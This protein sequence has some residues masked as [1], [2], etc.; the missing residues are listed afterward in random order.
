MIKCGF[1]DKQ[2]ENTSV[3][4]PGLVKFAQKVEKQRPMNAVCVSVE[5]SP[6]L[7]I[8]SGWSP[9]SGFEKRE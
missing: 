3:F 8:K 6:W 9:S 7:V 1:S 5:E 2:D 4:A